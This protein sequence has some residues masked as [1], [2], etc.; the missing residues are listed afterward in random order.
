MRNPEKL[1]TVTVPPADRP[2]APANRHKIASSAP[3]RAT[4]RLL[5]RQQARPVRIERLGDLGAAPSV[6][7]ALATAT[8]ALGLAPPA[9]LIGDWFGSR[10]VIAP[11]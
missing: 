7:R 10:A 8:A 5:A 11:W 3:I 2:I 9:A 1:A 6:L 4:L